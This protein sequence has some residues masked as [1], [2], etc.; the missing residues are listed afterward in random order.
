MCLI[1]QATL[2][3]RSTLSTADTLSVKD[4]WGDASSVGGAG[5]GAGGRGGQSRYIM[6]K[7]KRLGATQKTGERLLHKAARMGYK[8][9]AAVV[10]RTATLVS[11]DFEPK[12]K[13]KTCREGGDTGT[14]ESMCVLAGALSALH[15]AVPGR[16]ERAGERRLHAAAR[17]VFHRERRDRAHAAGARSQ[18]ERVCARRHQVT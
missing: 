10:Q 16:R 13:S 2:E 11:A 7:G 4:S 14:S 5:G 3:L 1:L 15:P 6:W 17:G 18:R 8:V 9:S 12:A